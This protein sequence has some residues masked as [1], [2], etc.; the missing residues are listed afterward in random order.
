M[1]KSS[2][3]LSLVTIGYINSFAKIHKFELLAQRKSAY[4]AL[5]Q[6][7]LEKNNKKISSSILSKEISAFIRGDKKP[8]II[9]AKS[10]GA[11][12]DSSKFYPL[13]NSA[14]FDFSKFRS[15][16]FGCCIHALA[17]ASHLSF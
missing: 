17:S 3:V 13:Q 4:Q 5:P 1:L 14:I 2:F 15:M 11:V 7:V 16:L 10:F 6:L 12:S 9:N 8:Q